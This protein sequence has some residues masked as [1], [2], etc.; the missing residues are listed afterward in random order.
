M[1]KRFWIFAGTIGEEQG[2][3]DDFYGSKDT[4]EE[5]LKY[6]NKEDINWVEILDTQEETKQ[7]YIYNEK[8]KEWE[9][10]GKVYIR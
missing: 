4:I 10:F 8:N 3:L 6:Q 1:L 5:A 9:V 7:L 2:G